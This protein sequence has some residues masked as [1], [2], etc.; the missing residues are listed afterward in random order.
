MPKFGQMWYGTRSIQVTPMQDFLQ[1]YSRETYTKVKGCSLQLLQRWQHQQTE[2]FARQWGKNEFLLLFALAVII[3]MSCKTIAIKTFTIGYQ[4]YT[5]K[6]QYHIP[7]IKT[8][9]LTTGPLCE[10]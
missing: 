3:G 2:L 1:R 5:L 6:N 9:H 4:D 10:E 7:L 8:D